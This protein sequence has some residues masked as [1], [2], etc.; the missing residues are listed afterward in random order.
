[1]KM[2]I[3][4]TM[5]LFVL[6][7]VIADYTVAADKK[8]Q[9]KF[10]SYDDKGTDDTSDDTMQVGFHGVG[11]KP[12]IEVTVSLAA[13]TE[14][15]LDGNPA[16]IDDLE[17]LYMIQDFNGTMTGAASITGTTYIHAVTPREKN[18]DTSSAVEE[19]ADQ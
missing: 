19:S 11:D 1:M 16:T 12:E 10:K 4:K 13:V 17:M 7:M 3:F 2:G 15:T 18:T 9:G 14:I 6:C 8:F 5:C